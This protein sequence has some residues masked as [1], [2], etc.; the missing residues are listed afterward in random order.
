MR[1]LAV[2]DIHEPVSRKGYIHFCKDLYKEWDCDTV[3]FIGDVID[4]SAVSF[5]AANPEAPGPHDEYKLALA[6]V[7]RWYREFPKAT[8]CIGNHDF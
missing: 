8:V 5:H 1:V 3:V 6:G 2:G 4:W 7:Q